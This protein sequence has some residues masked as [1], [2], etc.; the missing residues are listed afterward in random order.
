MTGKSKELVFA[1]CGVLLLALVGCSPRPEGWTPVFEQTSTTF[2]QTEIEYVASKLDVAKAELRAEH[3]T[4][5]LAIEQAQDSVQHLLTYYLPLLEA[6]E[7]AYNAYRH[8]ILDER[9]RTTEDLDQVET[10]LMH[11]AESGHGHLLREMA[12]PLERLEDARVALDVNADEASKELETL[13]AELNFLL[14][15]GGLVLI[16]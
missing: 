10:I 8:F 12:R 11:V 2:L 15:K 4:A 6:R 9:A 7:R 5:S 3:E 1:F 14:L 13:A 16:E